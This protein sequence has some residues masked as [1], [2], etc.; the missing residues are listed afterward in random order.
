MIRAR[1]ALQLGQAEFAERPCAP[2][3]VVEALEEGEDDPGMETPALLAERVGSPFAVTVTPAVPK[4][5][6]AASPVLHTRLKRSAALAVPRG[7]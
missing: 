4:D 6:Q 7:F 2:L 1:A 5:A 3:A